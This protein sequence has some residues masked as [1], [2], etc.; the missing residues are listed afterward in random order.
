M[1]VSYEAI[2]V[3]DKGDGLLLLT[4]NRPQVANA[5]N[6]QM[7]RDLLAFFE[8]VNADPH[9]AALLDVADRAALLMV[10]RLSHLADGRPVDLEWIRFRGDRMTL[11][12]EL[13]RAAPAPVPRVSGY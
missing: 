1:N 5:L 8:A 11:Q 3:E 4:L 7:R 9:S 2:A 10:E 6:T 13:R 12:T